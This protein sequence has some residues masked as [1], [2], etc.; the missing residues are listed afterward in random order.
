M[1]P[2][3][4]SSLEG[5]V[6]GRYRI[7]RLLGAGGMGVVYRGVHIELGR[8]VAI[9]VLKPDLATDA[10]LVTRFKAEARAAASLNHPNLAA[11]HDVAEADGFHYFVMDL[12]EGEDLGTVIERE[13]SLSLRQSL[14]LAELVARAL[15]HAH[16][17]G[18]IHRDVK[19]QNILIGRDGTVKLTDF[20]IARALE[21][22]RLTATGVMMGTP[23]YL[24]PEQ[25]LGEPTDGRTDVYALGIV[26]FEMA[27]GRVPFQADTPI[28]TAMQQLHTPAPLASAFASGIPKE[29]DALLQKALSKDPGLRFPTAAA[30][31]EA[32]ARIRKSTDN[33]HPTVEVPLP[34]PESIQRPVA[35]RAQAAPPPKS[36]AP[37]RA[38]TTPRSPAR[39]DTRQVLVILALVLVLGGG[40]AAL[41]L[42]HRQSTAEVVIESVPA[43]AAVRIDGKAS[44]TTPVRRDLSVG[45]HQI[46]VS[47]E[48]FLTRSESVRVARSGHKH[49][50]RLDPE[51][52]RVDIESTPTGAV[53]QI[54]GVAVGTTPLATDLPTGIHDIQVSKEG[55]VPW[56]ER[57]QIG[58]AGYR[59]TVQLEITAAS[60]R[61]VLQIRTD[62][63][64]ASVSLNGRAVGVT[65]F[66]VELQKQQY[67][68]ELTKAGYRSWKGVVRPP[69]G[70]EA[71]L[72]LELQRAQAR[73]VLISMPERATVYLNGRPAG[74]TPLD[75]EVTPGIYTITL[76]KPG[77]ETWSE[78]LR[79]GPE[80]LRKTIRL[81]R[82]PLS[83]P[84]GSQPPP[85][86]DPQ[87]GPQTP[88]PTAVPRGPVARPLAEL[89]PAVQ[90]QTA[91]RS[92]GVLF[93][94]PYRFAVV[95]TSQSGL[96][97]RTVYV[98]TE[99]YDWF[100]V[101]VGMEHTSNLLQQAVARVYGDGTLLFESP[102]L[103]LGQGPVRIRVSVRGVSRLE[104]QTTGLPVAMTIVWAD[105]RLIKE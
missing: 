87:V 7:D 59:K 76:E 15:D 94:Q 24:A 36:R 68:V 66:R 35:R 43:G 57:V 63:T 72:N 44:G 45:T 79:V 20:G 65:P 93:G 17:K 70:Q 1:F 27:T 9:K 48:G 28:A 16:A 52:G 60:T 12:V 5:R 98:L 73:M 54:D 85:P 25:A 81:S 67:R 13:H 29:V 14:E 58:P 83:A 11:V 75:R 97:M 2:E 10:R 33:I 84:V 103:G 50:V 3:L 105:P 21:G 69:D 55:F 102:N 41:A 6:W 88:A 19:P 64:G 4:F 37:I 32:I 91:F 99:Q 100:E 53:V 96:L 89:S 39:A 31:A 90:F 101:T 51:T 40:V 80:G 18:V 61:F 42:S 8:P 46:E 82:A 78:R 49:T 71:T 30:F 86:P 92:G 104:L 95:H 77:Y 34:S 38:P 26:L 62:P 56:Q 47:K 74:A 23:E 22:S